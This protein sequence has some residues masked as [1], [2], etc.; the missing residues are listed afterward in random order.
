M[1]RRHKIFCL[2]A[3]A[4]TL[5]AFPSASSGQDIIGEALG[6]IILPAVGPVILDR[7]GGQILEKGLNGGFGKG[8]MLPG[9][10]GRVPTRPSRRQGSPQ[11]IRSQPSS[12][13]VPSGSYQSQPPSDVAPAPNAPPPV[14]PPE[15][16]IVTRPSVSPNPSPTEMALTHV[17]SAGPQLT[18]QVI[19]AE[20]TQIANQL[21][22]A[23][24]RSLDQS[25]GDSTVE[26]LRRDYRNLAH[27]EHR[28]NARAALLVNHESALTATGT[29]QSWSPLFK[30]A[31]AADRIAALPPESDR[32]TLTQAIEA[33][34]SE[35]T[36][37]TGSVLSGNEI[38][39]I[40]Q[41]AKNIRNMGVLSEIARVLGAQRRDDL[42]ARIAEAAAKSDAPDEAVTGLLGVSLAAGG[43]AVT[44][45]QLPEGIPAV[46]LYSPE[47]NTAPISFVC[48]DA[49]EI[50]LA[51]GEMVPL[52]Q[53]FVV[54]F[55]NGKGVV[56]RYTIND[57]MYRWVV[58]QDGWDVRQKTAVEVSIDANHSPAAFHYLLN[59]Q[60]QIA[61]A[62]TVMQHRLD[63]PARI[64]FDRGLGDGS[65]KSTLVTPGDYVVGVDP[66][67]AGWDLHLRPRQAATAESTTAIAKQ[68]WRSSVLQAQRSAS[69][70]PAE[71][72]VDALLD[73]IE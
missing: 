3:A 46:V 70:D 73:L 13:T 12:Q 4:G 50:T 39:V 40:A 14:D 33:L 48:D 43:N 45:M 60:P 30:A 9:R 38:A 17:V 27:N 25:R 63:G 44:D 22:Q 7:A 72:K 5:T 15:N 41:R 49:L 69:I 6:K 35:L 34:R 68:H 62:G 20:A 21:D 47:I 66:E 52:D 18:G 65:S 31:D 71:A 16:R 42:F 55:Q 58:D 56:K 29:G 57:G 8:G 24:M 36:G 28:D 67:T 64:D 26:A 32:Q 2:L 51:P 1:N 59:G 53:S 37:V 54:A 23:V 10:G 11:V 19:R 61:A